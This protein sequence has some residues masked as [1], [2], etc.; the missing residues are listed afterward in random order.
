MTSNAGLPPAKGVSHIAIASSRANAYYSATD[1]TAN[2]PSEHQKWEVVSVRAQRLDALLQGVGTIDWLKVDVGVHGETEEFPLP[3]FVL[4]PHTAPSVILALSSHG[5]MHRVHNSFFVSAEGHE[6]QAL[7]SAAG[8]FG[9][10][11]HLGLEFNHEVTS[12]PEMTNIRDLLQGLGL[13]NSNKRAGP[14]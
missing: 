9:S 7:C 11:R 14:A 6:L 12:T 5:V 4:A 8:M 3:G 10:V 13:N 2:K 1:G